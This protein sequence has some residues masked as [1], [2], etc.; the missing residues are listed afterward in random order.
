MY[1]GGCP[2]RRFFPS[3]APSWVNNAVNI[4]RM[5][6]LV[7]AECLALMKKLLFSDGLP[8]VCPVT[9]FVAIN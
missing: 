5:S 8:G 6:V 1:S 3:S 7:S 4:K 2:T 9:T